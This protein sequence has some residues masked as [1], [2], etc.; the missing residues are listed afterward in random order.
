[1][2]IVFATSSGVVIRPEGL[3]LVASL[4]RFSFSGIFQCRSNGDTRTD[5]IGTHTFFAHFKGKLT[6]MGFQSGFGGGDG[7]IEGPAREPPELVK[8]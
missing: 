2:A 4:M 5:R 1:M 3:R 6:D 8:P 7:S